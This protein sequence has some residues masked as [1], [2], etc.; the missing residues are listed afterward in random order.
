M[1]EDKLGDA[2]DREDGGVVVLPTDRFYRGMIEK[3]NHGR[4]SGV[5]RA[6]DGREIPFEFQHLTVLGQHQRFEDLQEGMHVG[7]DVS[8]TAHGLRVTIIRPE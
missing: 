5:V 4:R 6:D 3:L 1:N 8:R 7:Y 2:L